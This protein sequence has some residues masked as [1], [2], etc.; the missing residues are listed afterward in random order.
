MIYALAAAGALGAYLLGLWLTG[1]VRKA[2]LHWGLLDHPN[3]RSSHTVATPRAG[4]LAVLALGGLGLGV[5]AAAD[6]RLAAVLALLI[7][8]VMLVALADDIQPLPPATRLLVQ[9]L[10]AA[11][12]VLVFWPQSGLLVGAWALAPLW[13]AVLG[14]LWIV[15]LANLY[16]FMDGSDGLAGVQTAVG[17]GFLAAWLLAAGHQVPAGLGAGLALGA[18][19]FLAWNWTPARVFMGDVGSVTTGYAVGLLGWWAA[20]RDLPLDAVILAFGL[21]IGDATLTLLRRLFHGERVWRAHRCHYYQRALR[22]GYRHDQI[23]LAAAV[24]CAVLGALATLRLYQPVHWAAAWIGGLVVLGLPAAWI[25]W[26]TGGWSCG[27]GAAVKE[28]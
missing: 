10:A 2:V 24:L 14:P 5:A 19:A 27:E 1:W 4:G 13:A 7:L 6:H 28:Q 26:R 25:E 15:W 12:A 20:Q 9:G 8:P 21:F 3:P 23:A 18:L 16:N 11:G 17:G 22:L